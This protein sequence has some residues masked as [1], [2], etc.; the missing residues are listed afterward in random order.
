MLSTDFTEIGIGR[1]HGKKSKYGWY[2]TT[3]FG[4]R[5]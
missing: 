1:A 3:T 5:G 2:W 4:K